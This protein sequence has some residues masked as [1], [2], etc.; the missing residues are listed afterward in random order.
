MS[1]VSWYLLKRRERKFLALLRESN[2]KP[3]N[4][5]RPIME[6][7]HGEVVG[8]VWAELQR[9]KTQVRVSFGRR[10]KG[11]NGRQQWRRSFRPQDLAD[12]CEAALSCVAY[13]KR[14][15]G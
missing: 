10:V 6:F 2:G 14:I 13:V 8:S 9:G 5:S 4:Q 7:V 15:T 3:G 12:V 11:Q 1:L